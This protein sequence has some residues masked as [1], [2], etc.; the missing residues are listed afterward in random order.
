MLGPKL[1]GPKLVGPKLLG[2]KLVVPKLLGPKIVGLKLFSD[3]L[4]VEGNV[5]NAKC[6]FIS[7]CQT[8]GRNDSMKTE[9]AEQF[10]YLEK[11]PSES[12]FY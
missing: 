2:P 9:R 4:S 6:V 10:K 11:P 3:R 12:K 1:L 5:S 7:G 8:E